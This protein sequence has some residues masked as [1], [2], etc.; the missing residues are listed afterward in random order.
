MKTMKRALAMFLAMLMC[1][2]VLPPTVMAASIPKDVT[3][4]NEFISVS[5]NSGNGRFSIRTEEGQPER[6]NDQNTFLSFVGGLFG[7]DEN[8]NL[9]GDSDTSFT[10]FRI[11]GTDYIFGN[12]YSIPTKNISST[13]GLTETITSSDNK[14]IPEGCQAVIT[15]WTLNLGSD[16]KG[17]TIRQILLLFPDEPDAKTGKLDKNSGNV[18]IYYQID[19]HSG[20]LIKVGARILLDTMVGA[21]DGPEFQI[22]TISGNTLKVERM[23][24]KDPVNDQNVATE[25]AN[26]WTMPGY[27]VMKDTLDPTNPLATNVVAY[28]YTGLADYRDLDYMIVSHWNKL[29]NEKFEEFIDYRAIPPEQS[30]AA[31]EVSRT[32]R[33]VERAEALLEQKNTE[34]QLKSEAAAVPGAGP[35]AVDDAQKALKELERVQAAAETAEANYQ[36]AKKALEDLAS[37]RLQVGSSIIDPNLD[38]TDDKNDYGSADSAVAF[39]WR[40]DTT[41]AELVS[42]E[43]M[44]LGTVYGLGEI[45]DPTSVLAISFPNPVTTVEVDPAKQDQYKDY[46]VFD[47]NVEIENLASQRMK[48]DSIDVTMTLEKGLRFV[49]RDDMGNILR[50]STGAPQTSY[51]ST[52]TVTFQK[53]RTQAQI[54]QGIEVNPIQPGEKIAATFTVVATG[55]PWPT[56][57]QYMVTASSPQL[58]TEFSKYGDG[59]SEDVK[60]LY[61]SSRANFIFLPAV[62]SGTPSYATSVSPEECFTKDPKYITV[63]LTNIEAYDPGSSARGQEANANFNLFFEE[64]VTGRRYQIDVTDNVQ[65]IPTDDGLTGDMRISYT[66]GTLVDEDG[67]VL[68]AD[69][70]CELPMGEYRVAIDYIS[71]DEDKNAM[72]DMVTEQ[73]FLVTE[74]EEARI[75]E[76]G[77]LA[78]VKETVDFNDSEVMQKITALVDEVTG[79]IQELQKIAEKLQGT[80]WSQAVYDEVLGFAKEMIEPVTKIYDDLEKLSDFSN[81]EADMRELSK[82]YGELADVDFSSLRNFDV[83]AA[84]KG[85]SVDVSLSDALKEQLSVENLLL[86]PLGLEGLGDIADKYRISGNFSFEFYIFKFCGNRYRLQRSF[87]QLSA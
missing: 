80:D 26:Y 83:G 62:G 5:V 86:G 60:A 1:F 21:N 28:G 41:D 15:P 53:E 24:S 44:E 45:I 32:Q 23:L 55:K 84:I 43:S 69:L 65:C 51:G 63:N 38:F 85:V 14:D 72:L 22:G 7:R 77:V 75:R 25:N 64:V 46:G 58:E 11:N 35:K 18:Q 81:V 54:E 68:E 29:A 19:N 71:I 78:I 31:A 6:K 74:N 10:T 50:D 39:Y 36:A 49:K 16:G 76:P 9:I 87:Y 48:H 79:Y 17:V 47:I 34:Y 67:F 56:T 2:G 59:A 3:I 33:I 52:Q 73:T 37:D 42:G 13:M 66:N 12:S 30:A 61:N 20:E 4:G 70:G 82:T 40:G 8:G 57:R 27:W